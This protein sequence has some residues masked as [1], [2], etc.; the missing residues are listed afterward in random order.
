MLV[1]SIFLIGQFSPGA[2]GLSYQRAFEGMGMRTQR[3]DLRESR[4][5]LPWVM[6]NRVAHRLTINSGLIR[7]QS[8]RCFGKWVEETVLRSG[9]QALLSFPLDVVLAETFENL[10]RNGIRVVTFYPDN[11]FP[12]HYAARPE[13][14]AAARATDLCL[15][16]SERLAGKLREAGVPNPAF[17]PFAWDCEVFPYQH[18]SPQGTWPGVLFLGGWDKEREEFLEEIASHLPL[19]I[20]GPAYWGTRTKV[21]SRVRRCWQ[22]SDLRLADAARVIRE[23]AVCLNVL[24][25]Q[26][27]IDGTADG[28]IMRH[29][30]VPGAGGFL[31]STRSGGATTL[32]PEGDT[33]E[34][35]SDVREC[36]EKARSFIAD[37]A[38]RRQLSE[39]AHVVVAAQ[40]QYVDRA[41][42]IVKMLETLNSAL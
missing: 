30:E 29:F 26:H 13:T 32:F 41:R 37:H 6:R 40:H 18:A 4:G 39:R 33:G 15:I 38:A 19:R 28:V 31:L 35:F 3:I 10:R 42:Q 36:V 23:S 27:V 21:S 7:S 5:R 9:A 1:E 34:Y 25:N 11:P 14:L 2:L 12:P 24:R 8:L 20:Y 17:L 22:Q 16:W